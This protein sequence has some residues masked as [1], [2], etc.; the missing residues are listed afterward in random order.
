M[1]RAVINAAARSRATAVAVPAASAAAAAARATACVRCHSIHY[2]SR[3]GVQ[4]RPKEAEVLRC[5]AELLSA[6]GQGDWRT[7]SRLC[8][9]DITCFEP[10]TAG[11]QVSGLD[12]HRFFFDLGGGGG[13][14]DGDSDGSSA[15]AGQAAAAS[16][17]TST[18]PLNTM[19]SP[20]VRVMGPVA[21][22][23]YAR[24]TQAVGEGGA[25]RTQVSH[26]TRVWQRSAVDGTWKNVHLHK[27]PVPLTWQA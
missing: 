3:S 27:S 14:S 7:Y 20:V 17:S 6:I 23:S 2:D 26:E 22:V 25:P 11:Q 1:L 12:F 21:I 16:T 10:E 4:S 9:D 8:A 18:A 24:A 5:N 15:Q 13:E 19:C